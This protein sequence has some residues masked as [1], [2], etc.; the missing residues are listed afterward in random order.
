M[1]LNSTTQ[2][3]IGTYFKQW[4]QLLP[5]ARKKRIGSVLAVFAAFW[6]AGAIHA[7]TAVAGIARLEGVG[8]SAHGRR[9]GRFL[10]P[11][12]HPEK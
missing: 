3:T 8:P 12:A 11:L 1:D 6:L 7:P 2:V 5:A 10:L 4:W 9:H